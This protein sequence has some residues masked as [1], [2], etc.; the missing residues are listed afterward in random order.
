MTITVVSLA[1]SGV[2]TF[3]DVTYWDNDEDFL[4]IHQAKSVTMLRVEILSRV[5]IT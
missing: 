5:V 3:Q 2:E 4:Y 1:D